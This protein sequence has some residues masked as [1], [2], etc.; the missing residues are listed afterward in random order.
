MRVLMVTQFYPPVVG[1]QEAHVRNLAQALAVRGHDVEVAT[2]AADGNE[3]TFSD[4][5]VPVH[6]LHAA[7]Q[8]LPQLF[9]DPER[10]HSMPIAD[11]Q[12][13]AGIRRLLRSGRFDVLHAHDWSI[14]SALGPA[15]RLG[16]PVVFTQHDYS[17][18]CATKRLMRGDEVCPGPAPVACTRCASSQYGPIVGPGVVLANF[19]FSRVRRKQIDVFIPVSSVVAFSTGLPDRCSYEVIP[20]FIPDSL[21]LNEV[22]PHPNGPI[23]FVGDLS[24]DKGIDVLIEAYLQLSDAPHL[25]LAGRVLTEM[26]FDLP[27]RI[28]L[29]GVVDHDSVMALMRSASVVVV[30]SIVPDCCPTVVLEA[31]AAG[32]PVVAARSGGIVDQVEDGVT[33][34]L[35]AAGDSTALAAALSSIIHDSDGATA[36]GQRALDRVHLFTA[37]VVVARIENVYERLVAGAM[38]RQ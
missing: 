32:R 4:G 7:A 9:S 8:Y 28:E 22:V 6:R 34:L 15:R 29:L 21:L 37:T 33:G 16:T 23:V 17:H 12:F 19:A 18:I 38:A 24:R 30:P 11:P 31:M 35:V 26:P 2:I 13:R 5:L 25:V 14:N 10:P 20:N 3:G 27:E 36:M 1:G